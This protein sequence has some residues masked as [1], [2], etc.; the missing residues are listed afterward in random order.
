MGLDLDERSAQLRGHDD[1][2][3]IGGDRDLRGRIGPWKRQFVGVKGLDRNG[4]DKAEDVNGDG[5]INEADGVTQV[6]STLIADAHAAGLVVHAYTFRDD[7]PLARDF[8]GEAAQEYRQLFALGLDGVF[9][10]FPDTAFDARERL[11]AG[12]VSA[13]EFTAPGTQRYFRTIVQGEQAVVASGIFGNWESTGDRVTVWQSG[14][15]N[16]AARPVCR[17]FDPATGRHSYSIVES[18]CQAFRAQAGAVDEGIAFFAVPVDADG[19]CPAGTLAVDRLR[20]TSGSVAYERYVGAAAESARLVASGWTRVGIGFCG[21][22]K[23]CG[24]RGT[25]AG[26]TV[27]VDPGTRDAVGRLDVPECD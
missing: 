24:L 10:D 15:D 11:A 12:K 3:G 5:A 21:A 25:S 9:S 14:T 27:M 19:E 16:A 1:E 4:D 7:V 13:V 17:I 26:S 20:I 18:E 6:F 8:A 2:S 23:A 22:P